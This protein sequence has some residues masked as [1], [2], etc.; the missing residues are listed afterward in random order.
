MD[1]SPELLLGMARKARARRPLFT[2][3]VIVLGQLLRQLP[4]QV[5][6]APP[7]AWSVAVHS[8][9]AG[10]AAVAVGVWLLPRTERPRWG[11]EWDAELEWL[12]HQGSPVLGV[13]VRIMLRALQTAVVLH[14]GAWHRS[15]AVRW[16]GRLEPLWMGLGS[17]IA[18]G[19]TIAI[20]LYGEG[21][22]P[23]RWQV[24][25]MVVASLLAGAL[26]GYK[27]WKDR[28]ARNQEPPTR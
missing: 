26:S 16:V 4:S 3:R 28:R 25:V 2:S 23:P 22:T 5:L 27:E 21:R 17:A 6:H 24:L 7:N 15:S 14:F 20:G 13:A 1:L 11:Q 19:L 10:R 18:T 12:K 8:L 9:R